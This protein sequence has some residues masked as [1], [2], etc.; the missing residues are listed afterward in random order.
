MLPVQVRPCKVMFRRRLRTESP[1]Q[2]TPPSE[3]VLYWRAVVRIVTR[4]NRC[5][6]RTRAVPSDEANALALYATDRDAE[7]FRF[8]VEK[9]QNRSEEHTLNSSHT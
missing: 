3:I 8:L 2:G 4:K 7:A 9:H 1:W 6:G 5:E